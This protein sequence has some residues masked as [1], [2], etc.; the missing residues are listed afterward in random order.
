MIDKNV[1]HS[2]TLRVMRQVSLSELLHRARGERSLRE[3]ARRC[4]LAVTT[5]KLLEENGI[6]LPSRETMS[7]LADAYGLPPDDLAK[8]AYG[9]YFEEASVEDHDPAEVPA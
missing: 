3:M 7:I 5:I 4:G 2:D 8:A 6:A 1:Q 9:R